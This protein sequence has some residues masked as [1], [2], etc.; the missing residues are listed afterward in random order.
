MGGRKVER[1]TASMPR[2]TGVQS[3][4]KQLRLSESLGAVRYILSILPAKEPLPPRAG[5]GKA[6]DGRETRSTSREGRRDSRGR[7]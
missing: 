7:D 1:L 5:S 3:S 4:S 2:I 6:R